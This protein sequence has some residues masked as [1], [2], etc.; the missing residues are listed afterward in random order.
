MKRSFFATDG[1]MARNY[2]RDLFKHIEELQREVA[3]LRVELAETERRSAET[4]ADHRD[5]IRE[6]ETENASLREENQRLLNDN[7]R[8]KR[9]INNNSKNS[10][11]PPSTDQKPSKAVNKYNSRTKTGRKPGG[12]PGHEGTTLTR[13]SIQTLIDS[14]KC[15]HEIMDIGNPSN[16][17]VE[18]FIVDITLVPKV[19]E[20]RIHADENGKYAIPKEYGSCVTYGSGVKSMCLLLHAQGN[21]PGLR[22]C[23][24]LSGITGGL[25]NLSE[26]TFHNVCQQ[27]AA[28]SA[29]AIEDIKTELMNSE[30]LY[31]DATNVTVNGV[32]EYIRNQSTP[33]AVLY[34]PMQTKSAKEL[35]HTGIIGC[36]TGIMV[37]DHETAL[38]RFG[39]GHAE[40]GAHILRYL[41]KNLEETRH[42]WNSA[43]MLLF[44]ACNWLNKKL[45]A[46]EGIT[47][48][49]TQTMIRLSTEYDQIL[50]E[51]R[52]SNGRLPDGDTK[53]RDRALLH[54][55][56][57]YKDNH[58]LFA[59]RDDVDFTN[60]L[61]E[62]DLR[63]CK[64]RQKI[65]GG[66]RNQNGKACYCIILSIIETAKRKTIPF[67]QVVEDI[68]SGKRVFALT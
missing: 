41:K 42:S 7:I 25:I 8:F 53:D 21:V 27:F 28:D 65:S 12:Q 32:Q 23:E 54:R 11:L 55:L 17:Y 63:K 30:V 47:L 19:L 18:R 64:N 36:Y 56:A 48:G 22:A 16:R 10:S 60:N 52:M 1:T 67:L 37:H 31:T 39:S 45:I 46:E 4:I 66:F 61:S 59:Y 49:S 44:R 3:A 9:I 51:G 68:L 29:Q 35:E 43:M 26:G 38:Y 5:R 20:V 24:I 62:R 40:C 33:D 34:S 6:L 13:E 50:A 14:K 58:L 15:V 57:K 2:N